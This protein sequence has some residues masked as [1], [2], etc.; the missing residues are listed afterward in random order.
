MKKIIALALAVILSTGASAC[1]S[2]TPA[3]SPTTVPSSTGGTVTPQSFKKFKIGIAEV[4]ANDES[5]TRRNFL[6]NY[7]APQYNVEFIFSEQCTDSEKLLTFIENCADA[8]ADAVISYQNEDIEQMTQVSQEYGMKYIVNTVRIQPK[9]EAAFAG[10]YDNFAAFGSNQAA[11]ADLFNG[12]LLENASADGNEGFIICSGVA[13]KGNLQHTEITRGTLE[14]LQEKYGLTFKD[15]LKTIITTSAPL[16]AVNDK[17][18]SIYVYPGSNAQ[19]GWLQGL[20]AAIQTGRYATLL[21]AIQIYNL[22]GVVVDEAEASMNKNLKVAS[23]AVV[24][25]TLKTSFN[26]NDR[27]GNPSIDMAT[28]K[29]VSVLCAAGFAQTYNLLTGYESAT[30]APNG[31]AAELNTNLWSITD[32]DMLEIVSK[33]DVSGKWIADYE[34]IDSMLGIYNND[35]TNADMQAVIES[36]TYE[37]TLKRLGN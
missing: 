37:N 2:K 23:I 7:I 36:M 30:L 34:I 16:E 9:T 17:G 11:I 10:G 21:G 15:E 12:W 22:V 25:E 35:L 19:E 8:G 24:S 27:F 20:T 29:P 13:N 32:K 31:E 18:I 4:Q 14:A 6:E 33:W 3:T 1:G 26:T 5:V 28:A